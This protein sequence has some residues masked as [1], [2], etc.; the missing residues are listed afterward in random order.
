MGVCLS[1]TFV[2]ETAKDTVTVAN[3]LWNESRKPNGTTSDL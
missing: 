2:F 1:V 3:L